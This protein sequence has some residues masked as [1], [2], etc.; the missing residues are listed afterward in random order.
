[1]RVILFL[2]R[3]LGKYLSRLWY[4]ITS[5]YTY[6]ILVLK[7]TLGIRGT[8]RWSNPLSRFRSKLTLWWIEHSEWFVLETNLNQTNHAGVAA[9]A[10]WFCLRLPSYGPGFESQAH[11]ICFFQFVLLKLYWDETKINKKRPGLAHFKKNNA[12]SMHHFLNSIVKI[13]SKSLF[14]NRFNLSVN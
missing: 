14:L 5:V 3:W 2:G 12:S 7:C 11:H 8:L 9:I 4:Q 13:K 6:Y 1:M 10:P